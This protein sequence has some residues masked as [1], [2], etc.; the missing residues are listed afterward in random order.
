MSAP[1]GTPPV[2]PRADVAL[3]EG[4]HS[5]QLDVAVRLNTNE[6]P[7]APPDAFVA[8]L[9]AEV[10]NVEWHRYPDRRA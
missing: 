9:Q 6:S 7:V 8:A 2:S 10:A 5:P 1:A 3:M 4:Y